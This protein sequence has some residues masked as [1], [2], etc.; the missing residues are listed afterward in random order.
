MENR[1]WVSVRLSRLERQLWQIMNKKSD[2]KS[3]ESPDK[4]V[5]PAPLVEKA[6][7]APEVSAKIDPMRVFP[8]E[9]A[10]SDIWKACLDTQNQS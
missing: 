5:V 4:E 3:P 2:K 9:A 7:Y 6:P 10:E 8:T 1:Q